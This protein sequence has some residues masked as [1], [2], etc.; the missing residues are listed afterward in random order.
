MSYYYEQGPIRPPSEARSLLIR[1]TRNCPWNK[2]AFCRVYKRQKFSRRSVEEILADVDR[3]AE[4][5]GDSFKSCFL[6]DGSSI[7]L[8][9]D[10]LVQIFGRIKEK[11]QGIDR[12]TTYARAKDVLKKSADDLKRLAEAGLSRIHIGMESGCDSVLN[13]VDKGATAAEM[14]E[15]GKRVVQSGISLSEYI[16]LGLGGKKWTEEHALESARVINAINPAFIRMR[17]L[18]IQEHTPLFEKAAAGEFERLTDSEIIEEERLFAANLDGI[19]AQVVSDHSLN[20][21]MEIEGRLPDEK[22]KLLAI[23]DRFI[24]MDARDR[25]LFSLGRRMGALGGMDDYS[26]DAK[27]HLESAAAELKARGYK[28][29]DDAVYDLMGM[30][31]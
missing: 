16:L 31:M 8:P 29:V 15:A 6:Q 12:I 2:C 30:M 27:R 19:Q 25:E 17:T 3:A 7:V 21:L 24:S 14:I 10:K 11:F 26:P 1:L 13:F 5:H 20:L 23:L 28:T 22:K 4:I 18:R 9:A